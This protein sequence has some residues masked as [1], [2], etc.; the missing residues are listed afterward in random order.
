MALDD[1]AL[2]L[3]SDGMETIVELDKVAEIE[4]STALGAR[5]RRLVDLVLESGDRVRV[6]GLEDMEKFEREIRQRVEGRSRGTAKGV[7]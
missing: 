4:Q 5:R 1:V 2:H 3:A 7:G 6:E